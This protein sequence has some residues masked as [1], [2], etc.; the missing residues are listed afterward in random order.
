MK[1]FAEYADRNKAPVLEVLLKNVKSGNFLEISSG[2]GQ[3]ISHFAPNFKDV[4][5]YPTEYD[6]ENLPSIKEYTKELSNVQQPLFFDIT[7][8]LPTELQNLKFNY[9]YNANMVHISPWATCEGLMKLCKNYL[10]GYLFLYGPYNVDGKYTSK[11]NEEFDSWLKKKD[12]N[13]GIRNFEDVVKEAEKNGLKFVER[14][15]M[16]ANNFIL[17]FKNE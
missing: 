3:H 8:E 1:K 4:I 12:S 5:F 2:T 14:V 11:G 6:K 15:S 9:I 17:I 13:F 10:V 16:P 7:Q